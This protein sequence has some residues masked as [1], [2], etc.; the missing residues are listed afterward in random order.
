MSP[1]RAHERVVLLPSAGLRDI[2]EVSTGGRALPVVRW[3]PDPAA[4]G[5]LAN[6]LAVSPDA[7]AISIMAGALRRSVAN[8]IISQR[9]SAQILFE[10]RWRLEREPFS[11]GFRLAP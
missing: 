7:L 4:P 1:N 11:P 5:F 10:V 2:Q 9:E 3:H 8:G 6:C